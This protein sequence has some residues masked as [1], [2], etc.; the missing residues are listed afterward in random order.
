[1][2]LLRRK[3]KYHIF[4]TPRFSRF[5]K[6]NT[7]AVSFKGNRVV[8]FRNGGEFFLALFRALGEAAR[9]VCLEF[10]I[11]KDDRVG[12][13]FADCLLAAAERGVEV[14]LLYDYFGCIDTPNSYFRR[15]EKGGVS[16]LP[17]NPPTFK[18]GIHWL[19]KRDHRKMAIIDGERAFLGGLNIAEEYAGF[20]ECL[21]KWRDVGIM[22]DGPAVEELRGLFWDSWQ[23]EGGMVPVEWRNSIH[24]VPEAGGDEVMIVSGGPHHN[25]SFIRGS[26][27]MAIAGA[28]ASIKVMNPYF[29]PGPRIVRSLL[30]AVGRG[31]RVQLVLPA[32]SD[33]PLVRLVSRGFYAPLL[34]AGIEIFERE[35]TM[36]HA[37]VMLID[38]YWVTIGSANLDLR[39][40]HRN[41]E[42]NVIVDSHDFGSQVADMFAADL[43]KSRRVTLDEHERRGWL[44]RLLERL[45]TPLSRFL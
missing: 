4:R 19:D 10:Y 27:R 35:G 44:E 28:S 3:R 40:F 33:V 38:D 39:S 45:L 43:A 6:R 30:R 32:I 29:V 31:V 42:V 41:Y 13:E 8:L 22:I 16:C 12:R 5:F 2:S 20:G 1:M 9:N 34:K 24:P 15:L 36:L 7:D 21:Y 26:F 17:F 25:R 14:T 11:I 23:R 18:R 37:K